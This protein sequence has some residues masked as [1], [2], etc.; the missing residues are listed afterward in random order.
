MYREFVRR[1][2]L[3][4]PCTQWPSP[5]AREF[6]RKVPASTFRPN[7]LGYAH[8]VASLPTDVGPVAGAFVTDEPAVGTFQ[9]TGE[10]HLSGKLE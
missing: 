9:P 1:T 5:P 7:E 6:G 3:G 4:E 2:R 8:V 10:T